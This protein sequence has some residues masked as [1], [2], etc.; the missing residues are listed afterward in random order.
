[1]R[2]IPNKPPPPYTP[3]VAVQV[4]TLPSVLP[5]MVDQIDTAV[6]FS[7]DVL[8]S[9]YLDDNLEGVSFD[10]QIVDANIFKIVEKGCLKFLFDICKDLAVEHYEKFRVDEGP[11]W[12]KL[13]NK[14]KL[15]LNAPFNKEELNRY[16]NKKL[17]VLLGYEKVERRENAIIRWSRKKR[18]HV[19]EILVLESQAE[20]SE[21]TSYD[22]DELYVK[23]DVTNEIMNMLLSETAE[24]LSKVLMKK[25][26]CEQ[27]VDLS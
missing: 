26:C 1:M 19:D 24:V 17:K 14:Q 7:A 22:K 8:Y 6:N 13:V 3:P 21:W 16:L 20:E 12:M 2:E 27:T 18:D 5:S 25:N 23:N 15:S 9:A 4:P 11:S 10:E